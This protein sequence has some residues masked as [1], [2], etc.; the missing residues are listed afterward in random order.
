MLKDI[1]ESNFN[2]LLG[3]NKEDEVFP[4]RLRG[5]L[6][7]FAHEKGKLVHY[8]KNDNTVTIFAKHSTMHLLTG[9]GFSQIG[10]TRSASLQGDTAGDSN[11]NFD[12]TLVSGEQH[13]STISWPGPDDWWSRSVVGDSTTHLYPFFPVKMLFGTGFEWRSWALVS[14]A[15]TKG[16]SDYLTQYLTDGWSQ[17]TFDSNITNSKNNSYSADYDATG[18]SL[19][20][21][22]T[23]N[24][25]YSSTLA[26]PA[27]TDSDWA[28][29]GAVKNGLYESSFGD[30]TKIETVGG[31]YFSTKAYWGL[32]YPSFIYAKR[33]ARFY[34]SGSEVALNFDSN[35]ENKI[36]FTVTMP[37]QTGVSTGVFYPYNGFTLKEAGLFCDARFRL[38]DTTPASDSAS[39]D[40]GLTEF[41]N[42]ERMPHGMLFAK[43]YISPITKSHSIS[44]TA[45]WSIYL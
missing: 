11:Y 3:K 27:I 2:I 12:G 42:F 30:S 44:I 29:T 36:T 18:D 1:I 45:R 15:G 28:I 25:I 6:E 41:T 32:G 17:A 4:Y 20:N 37:E 21:N 9:E 26:T 7:I 13:F 8:E 5:E 40:S 38:R 16:D 10:V 33:E 19:N 24:D 39:D 23:M 43:R 35:V 22:R 14:D 34:Q 31:E